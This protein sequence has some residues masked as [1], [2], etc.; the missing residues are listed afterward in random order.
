MKKAITTNFCLKT[1]TILFVFITIGLCLFSVPMHKSITNASSFT[2]CKVD[3]GKFSMTMTANARKQTSLPLDIRTVSKKIGETTKDITYYCF[4]WKDLS[5]LRFRFSSNIRNLT[6]EYTAFKFLLTNVQD[7][8]LET[9]ISEVA[10][11][12]N[13]TTLYQGSIVSNTFSQFD[14]YYYIDKQS[15]L[16]ETPTRCKGNDFGLYKF[17]FVYTYRTDD[18]DLVDISIGDIYVAVLPQDIN[19]VEQTDLKILYSVSSSNKLMNVF[20]L[21]LSNDTYKY[22]N[23]K[24]IKWGVVGMDKLKVNYVLTNKM[25][26][27]NLTQ[28]ANY[29]TIWESLSEEEISGTNFLFNSNDIEGTWTVYCTI[30]DGNGE[31][32]NL[33]VQNLSTLKTEKKSYVW[34]VLL[35][36]GLALVLGGVISFIVIYK[37]NDKVW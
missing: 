5:S 10:E 16:S 12:A 19:T 4:Q 20:N 24:Y 3:D 22:V 11:S 2:N 18:G 33:S 25:K 26:T 6:T 36:I 23:P 27:D 8:N 34:L 13:F 9:E 29:K 28:Y 7:D 35:I 15:D 32:K 21:Y 31:T 1:L 14:F 30:T 17:D 37:K